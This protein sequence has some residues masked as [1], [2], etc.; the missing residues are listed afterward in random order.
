MSKCDNLAAG[1]TDR[2]LKKASAW[3]NKKVVVKYT[4]KPEI[5]ERML[6]ECSSLM[7]DD[8]VKGK[9]DKLE[10]LM[11]GPNKMSGTSGVSVQS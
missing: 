4:V 2:R 8:S 11:K 5:L 1:T 3:L 10:L 7:V 9:L 6:V